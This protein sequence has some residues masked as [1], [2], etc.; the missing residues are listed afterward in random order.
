MNNCRGKKR[1]SASEVA[2]AVM[3]S[4]LESA[5]QFSDSDSEDQGVSKDVL[6]ILAKTEPPSVSPPPAISPPVISTA[7]ESPQPQ[8]APP[9]APSTDST[10]TANATANATQQQMPQRMP[11]PEFPHENDLRNKLR[12]SA[13]FVSDTPNFNYQVRETEKDLGTNLSNKISQIPILT[14]FMKSKIE[15]FKMQYTRGEVSFKIRYFSKYLYYFR[16]ANLL[17]NATNLSARKLKMKF[18]G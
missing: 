5:A 12:F 15:S 2:L 10:P 8:Q 17:F 4:D 9:K 16:K 7:A 14:Q 3:E 6:E 1:I 18:E 11:M 13:K